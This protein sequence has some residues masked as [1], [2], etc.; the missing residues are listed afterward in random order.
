VRRCWRF[1]QRRDVHVHVF[2]SS[3][4]GAVVANIKRKEADADRMAAAM[5]LHMADLSTRAVR[6]LE[7]DKGEYNPAQAMRLPNWMG[8]A[9]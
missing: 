4:E 1:G 5:V 2:A 7:R 9:A 8:K 6:G 3:S